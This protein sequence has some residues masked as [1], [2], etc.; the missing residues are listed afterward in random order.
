MK[1]Q[2]EAQ[3]RYCGRH[4]EQDEFVLGKGAIHVG[5]KFG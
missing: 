1:N 2:S 3:Q 4:N 5:A